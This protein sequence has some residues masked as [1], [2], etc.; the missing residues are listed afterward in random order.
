MFDS[1]MEDTI[2]STAEQ[3]EKNLR[4]V[5]NL[6]GNQQCTK[7]VQGKKLMH[8]KI[9]LINLF[10]IASGLFSKRVPELQR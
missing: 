3:N 8:S 7:T 10:Y 1:T 4:M 6:I 9:N 5:M 2:Q